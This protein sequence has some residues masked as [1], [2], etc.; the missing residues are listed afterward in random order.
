LEKGFIHIFLIA[1]PHSTPLDLCDNLRFEKIM[2]TAIYTIVVTFNRADLLIQCIRGI[3]QQKSYST[4]IL[5]VDN[6]STDGTS[7]KVENS[8]VLHDQSAELLS[9]SLNTGGAGGFSAGLT[10]AV[11][12]GAEWIWMMDD[13][14][15]PHPEALAELMKVATDPN[16]VYGSLAVAGDDTA[17]ET[18]LLSPPQG[19]VSRVADIPTQAEVEMLP[20]LGL[21]VHR[22]LVTK[23]GVPDAGFFISGD[24]AEYCLRARRAG[25]KI[26]VAG[27][28]HIN[29]PKSSAHH[30]TLLRKQITYLSL[31]PWKRYYDTRNRLLIAREYYGLR[32]F[33]Q[34]VPGS[35]VRLCVAIAREPRK[36]AQAHAFFAGFFDGLLGI[37]GKRHEKWGIKP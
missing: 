25:A 35:L 14:A 22:D 17:W 11:T 29:H 33:T 16:N 24:D 7:S 10:H 3:L 26:I 13:D 34:T 23:I 4:H 30:V 12:G 27:R 18:T 6:A 19:K 1:S 21:L 20:L 9:L 15:E 8:R 37:K 28:S 2:E 5:I 32:L 31:P 36:L